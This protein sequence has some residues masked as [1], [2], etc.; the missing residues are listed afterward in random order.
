MLTAQSVKLGCWTASR[1]VIRE[2]VCQMKSSLWLWY[3]PWLWVMLVCLADGRLLVHVEFWWT[4]TVKLSGYQ[5]TSA[6]SVCKANCSVYKDLALGWRKSQHDPSLSICSVE[7]ITV[8][9]S[10]S[11]PKPSSLS[12]SRLACQTWSRVGSRETGWATDYGQSRVMRF[13]PL[14]PAVSQPRLQINNKKNDWNKNT[15]Q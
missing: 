2:H 6:D 8:T 12:L 10:P 1:L 5:S 13:A 7:V 15:F 11:P 3:S 14:Q 4:T 9:H